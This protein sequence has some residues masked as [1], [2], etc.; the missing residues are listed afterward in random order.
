[1]CRPSDC[2]QSAIAISCR[3]AVARGVP[4]AQLARI[5]VEDDGEGFETLVLKQGAGKPGAGVGVATVRERAELIGG[6][7]S[8]ESAPGRG[9]RVTVDVPSEAEAG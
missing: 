8:V 6:R 9:T 2:R 5:V 3:C 1:M 4:G 7:V